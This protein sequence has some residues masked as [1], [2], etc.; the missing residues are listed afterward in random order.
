MSLDAIA[1]AD[2]SIESAVDTANA[3][4]QRIDT[5]AINGVQY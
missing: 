1:L 3:N 5:K 4:S 2:K